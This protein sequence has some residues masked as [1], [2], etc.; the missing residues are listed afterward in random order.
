MNHEN[1]L[2]FVGSITLSIMVLTIFFRVLK[3]FGGGGG[4][5]VERFGFRGILG[6]DTV[7]TV[8][9]SSGVVFEK[10]RLVGFTAPDDIKGHFPYEL[11]GMVVLQHPDDSQTIV[12]SKLIKQIDVPPPMGVA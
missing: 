4:A 5:P 1:I 11:S 7:V 6:P 12:K 3:R 9:L 8:T 10:V 2:W